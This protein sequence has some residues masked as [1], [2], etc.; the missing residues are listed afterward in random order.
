[1]FGNWYDK[2]FQ[3]QAIKTGASQRLL[4]ALVYQAHIW[5]AFF[6]LTFLLDMYL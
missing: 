5:N 3:A 2:I 4:V 1:M 6:A